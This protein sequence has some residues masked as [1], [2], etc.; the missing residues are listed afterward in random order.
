MTT[1]MIF[2]VLATVLGSAFCGSLV[3]FLCH[4]AALM[5]DVMEYCSV[6]VLGIPLLCYIMSLSYFARSDGSPRLSFQA[7][8]ISNLINLAMDVVLMRIAHMGL[9]G[10]A[11]ATVLGY[12]GGAAWI[13]RY[14][15]A[16]N[17]QLR[18]VSPFAA[19]IGQF[20]RNV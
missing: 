11:L 20:L 1:Q 4:D 13:S 15:M 19:G 6:L 9:R 14:L 10:A 3:G 18:L 16:K 7:V 2:G 12:V 17:R 8:L 5:G